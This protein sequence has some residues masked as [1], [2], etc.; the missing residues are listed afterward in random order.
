MPPG[1]TATVVVFAIDGDVVELLTAVLDAVEDDAEVILTVEDIEE[2]VSMTEDVEEDEDSLTVVRVVV[3]DVVA[4]GREYNSIR[5]IP[6]PPQYS[7]GASTQILAQR[8]KST[9][10]ADGFTELPP[11][12]FQPPLPTAQNVYPRAS[13]PARQAS[14][15]LLAVFTPWVRAA[16]VPLC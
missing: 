6:H 9:A 4:A 11:A 3:E 14:T 5:P 16:V 12:Q 2:L 13:Q 1:E 7:S 10:T 8:S 15:D